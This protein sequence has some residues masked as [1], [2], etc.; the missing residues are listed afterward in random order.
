MAISQGTPF[1][2][3]DHQD[4]NRALASYLFWKYVT[5]R[6]NSLKWSLYSG[7][8]GIRNSN[9][10]IVEPEIPNLEKGSAAYNVYMKQYYKLREMPEE[11]FQTKTFRGSS[12]CRDVAG[13]MFLSLLNQ[14][15]LDDDIIDEKFSSAVTSINKYL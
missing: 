13:Q 4:E 14:Y 5:N 15:T 11:M 7:Y 3:L 9:Y 8:I 2:F 1:T 6:E 10:G 12:T